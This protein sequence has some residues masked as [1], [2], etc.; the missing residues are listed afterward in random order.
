MNSNDGR[1]IGPLHADPR[2]LNV[3]LSRARTKLILVGDRATFTGRGREEEE[4]AKEVYRRLFH[5]LDEQVAAG[6]ARVLATE[7]R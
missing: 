6:T 1:A 4:G 7:R 2:R 3:A 5:L